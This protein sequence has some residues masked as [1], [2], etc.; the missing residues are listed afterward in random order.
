MAKE[1]KNIR[2]RKRIK[3]GRVV[4]L[5]LFLAW[6]GFGIVFFTKTLVPSVNMFLLEDNYTYINEN[7][8]PSNWEA[9]DEAYN[10]YNDYVNSLIKSD[11][12]VVS[13]YAS[14]GALGKM[15]LN[16]IAFAPIGITILFILE[17]SDS[18]KSTSNKKYKVARA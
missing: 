6:L 10:S 13:F 15:A 7:Y 2:S 11:D 12:K 3:K 17:N 4:C 1:R 8:S 9:K 14:Q 18:T 5:I 16:I